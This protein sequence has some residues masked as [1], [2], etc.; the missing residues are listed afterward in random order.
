MGRRWAANFALPA[1]NARH[2]FC[3]RMRILALETSGL[4]GGVAALVD[5]VVQ[6]AQ[7]LPPERRSAQT[8]AAGL[9]RLLAQVG[10]RPGDVELVAVAQGP[11]SFTGLRVGVTTAKTLAYAIGCPVLGVSTLEAIA[12]QAP[13]EFSSLAVAMDAQ[14]GELFVGRFA[15]DP[16]RAD[17]L[18]WIT[19]AAIEPAREFLE[20]LAPGDAATGPA[21]EK[22]EAKAPAHARI[23]ARE[24][25]Q[26]GAAAV[27]QL[28]WRDFAAGRRDDPFQLAPL[29]LRPT[30]AE[31]QWARRAP[32]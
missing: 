31:E 24:F 32:A 27:G 6:S 2:T 8:L 21:L 25:W 7:S 11:G 15:R 9:E 26:P 23:V 14:R 20:R 29:Y 13:A 3:S 12:L 30:A 5:G 4:A 17:Q 16:A 10:W 18:S 1:I 22:L 19:D 28:A